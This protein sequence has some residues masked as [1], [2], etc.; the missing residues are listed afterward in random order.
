M[1]IATYDTMVHDRNNAKDGSLKARLYKFSDILCCRLSKKIVLE[2]NDHIN[3][4]A[5]KFSVNRNKFKR[6][7]LA[8]DNDLIFPRPQIKNTKK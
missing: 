3:D 1:Y 2:T 6:I 5:K 4:F 8:V 7:F